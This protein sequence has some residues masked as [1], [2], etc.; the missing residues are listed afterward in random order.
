MNAKI[1]G[2]ILSKYKIEYLPQLNPNI[3]IKDIDLPIGVLSLYCYGELS[4]CLVKKGVYSMGFPPSDNLLDHNLLISVRE[5]EVIV[6]ND[7]LGIIPLFYNSAE[8]V[9]STFPKVCLGSDKTIDNQGLFDYLKYGFSVFERTVFKEVRFLPF[10]SSLHFKGGEIITYQKEDPVKRIDEFKGATEQDIWKK[11]DA[12]CLSRE[13]QTKGDIVIPT[14]AGFDSRIANYFMHDRSR[15]KN[16]TYGISANQERSFEVQQAKQISKRLGHS[17]QQ[18]H[19]KDAFHYINQWHDQYAFVANLHG[20]YHIEFYRKINELLQDNPASMVSGMGGDVLCGI[21]SYT[22]SSNPKYLYHLAYTHGLNYKL[23]GVKDDFQSEQQFMNKYNYLME[24]VRLYPIIT[25]RLKAVLISYVLTIPSMMGLP[26]WTPFL[27]FEI[28]MSMLNLPAERRKDRTWVRDFFKSKDLL[29]SH[30]M[31]FQDTKNRVNMHLHN[32]YT[33]EPLSDDFTLPYLSEER[34]H[35]INEYLGNIGL[36]SK[37]KYQL[38][39]TRVVKE[40]LKKFGVT[41]EFSDLLTDYQTLK[42]IEM[43]L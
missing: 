19:L 37:I 22:L 33:F 26:A 10:Y 3:Q 21:N 11:F 20:M 12:Y 38:T 43:S 27:N 6:E 31:F 41:N 2:F 42:A 24:D 5:N 28:V 14:S 34:K 17:W 1:V 16:Y 29:P 36:K 30:N 40:I 15:V 32:N 9:V 8:A 23:D 39:T 35:E 18:I 4:A 25:M 13:Q 7:W